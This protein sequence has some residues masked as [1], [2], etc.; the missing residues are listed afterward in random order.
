MFKGT[1]FFLFLFAEYEMRSN[2]MVEQGE[3]LNAQNLTAL[4][5]EI[6][7]K[8]YGPDMISDEEIGYEWARIP[9]FYYNF[10]VYQY[11]TSFSAAIAV[12]HNIFFSEIQRCKH[13]IIISGLETPDFIQEAMDVMSEVLDEMETL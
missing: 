10:Y 8:Y 7:E 6:N 4:Y 5:K 1:L 2:E 11:A 9:H 13:L 12:A 3:G